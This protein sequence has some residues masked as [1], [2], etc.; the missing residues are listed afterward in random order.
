[1]IKSTPE[2][3][4]PQRYE[5][6]QISELAVKFMKCRFNFK[7]DKI[8]IKIF[9]LMTGRSLNLENYQNGIFER[10]IK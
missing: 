9:K 3:F 4:L 7:L 5:I 6:S 10:P 1:M 8:F 2:V